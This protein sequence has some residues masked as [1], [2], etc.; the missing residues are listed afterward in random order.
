MG[1]NV[2]DISI[3]LETQ[4]IKE[5]IRKKIDQYPKTLLYMALDLPVEAM[6][7]PKSLEKILLDN[8]C[9]RVY[10]LVGLDLTKIELLTD[11]T[12]ARITARFDQFLAVG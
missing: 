11:L 9:S 2:K 6:C 4:K 5:E 7:L 8:G 3:D 1:D 12:R 10:D